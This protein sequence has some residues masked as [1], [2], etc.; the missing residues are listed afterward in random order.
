MKRQQARFSR[1]ESVWSSK[2]KSL[3]EQIAAAMTRLAEAD[4]QVRR[5]MLRRNRTH[6]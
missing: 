4:K 5:Q 6:K 2:E 1:E 3:E